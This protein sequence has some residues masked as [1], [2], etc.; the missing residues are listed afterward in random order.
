MKKEN[1]H[2]MISEFRISDIALVAYLKCKGYSVARVDKVS[3]HKAEF[4]FT[5]VDRQLLNDYNADK[6]L[7]EPKQFAAMM[8]QQL[9]TARIA[10]K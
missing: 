2:S 4:V 10:T 5:N 7:V 3:D 8:R 1:I 9:Q 6:E